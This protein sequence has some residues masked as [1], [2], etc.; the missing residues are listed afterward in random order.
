MALT[1]VYLS[2]CATGS[3][4]VTGLKRDAISFEMVSIYYSEPANYDVVGIVKSSSEM[5][6]GER[7]NL[8]LALE[9]IKKQAAKVGANGIILQNTGEVVNGGRTFIS[10]G[11]GGGFFVNTQSTKQTISGTAIYIAN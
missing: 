10:K 11:Y 5:G 9:E 6:F 7:H 2:S 1:V 3:S 8:D 4:L